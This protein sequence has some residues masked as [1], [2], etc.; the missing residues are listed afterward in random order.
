MEQVL[1]GL[2]RGDHHRADRDP[3]E[4]AVAAPG[5][6]Q[7][8]VVVV[9]LA[10]EA[11]QPCVGVQLEELAVLQIFNAHD[12]PPIELNERVLHIDGEE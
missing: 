1:L 12:R 3:V 2:V 11:D 8:V 4:R 7:V 6:E 9:V 5:V 10:Q